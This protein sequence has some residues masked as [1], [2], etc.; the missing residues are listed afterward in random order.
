MAVSESGSSSSY[1]AGLPW[2]FKGS[3]LYQLH[4]VKAETA[5]AF[6]PKEFRLVEAFGYN[7]GGLFLAHYDDSPAGVFDELVVIAGIVWNLPTSCAWAAR[8]LVNS[9]EACKHGRKYVGLPS[10]VATFSKQRVEIMP[11]KPKSKYNHLLTMMGVENNIHRRKEGMEIQVTEINDSCS[12]AFCNINLKTAEPGSKLTRQWRG[13]PIRMSLP[14]FR[15]DHQTSIWG[16]IV[17]LCLFFDFLSFFYGANFYLHFCAK[18][19]T[20]LIV[21]IIAATLST[22]LSFLST[23]V[24]LSAEFDRYHLL[25]Y[26][27]L[28][29][30]AMINRH[31]VRWV[32]LKS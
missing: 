24:T 6:I 10:H 22:I 11:E 26:P 20:D 32:L 17:I 21:E 9:H 25:K 5:R 23:H 3:A 31:R 8:V 13:P 30:P 4:L 15:F 1:D 16:L 14:S 18:R 19:L 12:T 29:L 7:L 28:L 27:N 2:V